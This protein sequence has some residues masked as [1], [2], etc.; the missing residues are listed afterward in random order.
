MSRVTPNTVVAL[1]RGEDAYG[2]DDET[3]G[4]GM[5]DTIRDVM[6]PNPLTVNTQTSIEGAAQVMRANDIG[7]V[8]VTENGRLKGILTDRDIVVRAVAM[9]RHPAATFA[10]DVCSPNIYTVSADDPVTSAV[11]IMR[12]QA[13]RRLPVVDGDQLV[14]IVSIGDLAVAEDP[15]SAV[16]DIS[17]AAPNQ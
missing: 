4:A 13:L 2:G 6:M 17:A 15:Q 7:D 12:Q 1:H 3:T 5:A 8:L 11:E 9:G 10:G 16:A 14:G